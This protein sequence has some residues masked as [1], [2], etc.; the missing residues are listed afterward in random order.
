MIPKSFICCL[1]AFK[2]L[3]N[4]KLMDEPF[5]SVDIM[6]PDDDVTIARLIT[7]L[8]EFQRRRDSLIQVII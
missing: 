3:S 8:E 6:T 4:F 7:Y 1:I 5:P 2:L